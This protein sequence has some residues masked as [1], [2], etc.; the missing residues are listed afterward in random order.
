VASLYFLYR[1][2]YKDI[3]ESRSLAKISKYWQGWSSLGEYFDDLIMKS[4]FKTQEGFGK[5]LFY[6]FA[7]LVLCSIVYHICMAIKRYRSNEIGRLFKEASPLSFILMFT[8]ISILGVIIYCGVFKRSPGLLR[9]QV[10]LIPLFLIWGIFLIDLFIVKFKPKYVR[11]I[12]TVIVFALFI[13]IT[14]RNFPPLY[15]A[16]NA[17]MSGPTVRKLK[18]INAEYPW[19]IT[20][21]HKYRYCYMG[22]AY[23]YQ[24]G[25]KFRLG[26]GGSYFKEP[27]HSDIYICRPGS[28]P[29]GSICLDRKYFEKLNCVLLVHPE[30]AKSGIIDRSRLSVIE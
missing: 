5:V 21:S 4:V 14:V 2:I 27:G 3:I 23:Y 22:F 9:S 13:T 16:K 24:F 25:Y 10:F 18:K 7:S 12:L 26:P 20:F 8:S 30:L 17:S 6:I 1:H 29:K 15:R 19:S 11:Y 28:A